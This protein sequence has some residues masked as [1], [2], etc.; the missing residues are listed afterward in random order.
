MQVYYGDVE[1]KFL[2]QVFEVIYSVCIFS[3]VAHYNGRD[4]G[5]D[6]KYCEDALSLEE[7]KNEEFISDMWVEC[8]V[9]RSVKRIVSIPMKMEMLRLGFN[10]F[11]FVTVIMLSAQTRQQASLLNHPHLPIDLRRGW[12]PKGNYSL[13]MLALTLSCINDDLARDRLVG[14]LEITFSFPPKVVFVGSRIM[15]ASECAGDLHT[16]KSFQSH[17][18]TLN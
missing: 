5:V 9:I 11:H 12:K 7:R 10:T 13:K 8:H 14:Y 2:G 17:S 4:I 16:P 15:L 6:P 1:D 18:G 3:C